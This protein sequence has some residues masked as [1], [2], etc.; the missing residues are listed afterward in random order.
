M[1]ELLFD[2]LDLL[3]ISKR[4]LRFYD[5]FKLV[6]KPSALFHIEFDLCLHLLEP[7]ASNVPLKALEILTHDRLLANQ[8][9][10]L[11]LEVEDQV[12]LL[13]LG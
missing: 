6:S 7:C 8:V 4:V 12:G 9:L 13:A 5:L 1:L 3:G 11:S 10:D 2:H